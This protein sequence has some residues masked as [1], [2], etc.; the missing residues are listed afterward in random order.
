MQ[1]V[2]RA[3]RWLALAAALVLPC[4][5][6]ASLLSRRTPE[7]VVPDPP[8][9]APVDSDSKPAAMDVRQVAFRPPPKP[10]VPIEDSSA[11]G[12]VNPRHLHA[13]LALAR[14]REAAVDGCRDQVTLPPVDK[15]LQWS[16]VIRPAE[17]D[18]EPVQEI[19]MEQ[20]ILF[21]ISSSID[22]FQL[23]SAKVTET[24]LEFPAPD[25]AL[26]RSPFSDASLDRCVERALAGAIVDS[27]GAVSGE[28]FRIL[29]HAGEAVFDLR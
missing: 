25:G 7:A 13:M 3:A 23:V 12:S 22:A 10:S 15:L 20:S 14:A 18:R 5:A 1:K 6:L 2:L 29:G 17:G 16:T 9:P 19:S 11:S 21:E 8:V 27:P 24:W 26:L 4:F 28:A